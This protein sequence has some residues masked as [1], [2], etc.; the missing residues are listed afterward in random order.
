MIEPDLN[1]SSCASDIDYREI[2]DSFLN[3]KDPWD[4]IFVVFKMAEIIKSYKNKTLDPVD[5][6]LISGFYLHQTDL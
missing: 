1:I 2:F 4:R 5:E 3:S 6:R